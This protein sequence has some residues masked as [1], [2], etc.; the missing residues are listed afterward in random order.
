MD[1]SAYVD[2]DDNRGDIVFPWIRQR[3]VEL[4]PECVLDYGCG[5]ARF[6]LAIA[7]G[8]QTEVWAYD[9]DPGM[10]EQARRQTTS[11]EIK[12]LDKIPE[13]PA[14]RFDAA[15]ML[16]VWMCW[17]SEAEC[18]ENLT[19]LAQ[20]LKAGGHLIASVTH[21]CFRDRPFATYRTDFDMA[22]YLENGKPFHVQ[23]GRKGQVEITD[24]HWNLEAML[25]QASAAG[26]RLVT[27]KEHADEAGRPY[28]PWLSVVLERM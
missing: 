17:Q 1:P 10:R 24:T 9:R 27:L 8:L 14:G 19:V 15:F 5:D 4:K 20:A 22:H 23:V 13:I 21:P 26:F 28:P 18:L 2:S 7:Y 3:L 16:G 6:A 11:A 25:Q 12:L